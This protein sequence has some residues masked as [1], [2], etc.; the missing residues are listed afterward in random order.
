MKALIKPINGETILTEATQLHAEV[1]E[2]TIQVKSVGLCRTDLYVANGII[3]MT[4]DIILG[5]EFSGIIVDDITGTMSIGQSVAVNPLY[6]DKFMGLHFDG[7][8]CEYINVPITQIHP[9]TLPFQIAAYL[10]PVAASMAVLNVGLNKK[11]VGA[12][13]GRNRI[14]DLTF[15][16]MTHFGYNVTLLNENEEHPPCAFDYIIETVFEEQHVEKM[17]EMLKFGGTLIV[18]SR[19][20]KP[21]P[22]NAS[23][24]VAKSLVFKAANYNDFGKSLTWLER[25]KRYIEPLLGNSYHVDNWKQAFAEASGSESKKTFIHF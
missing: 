9:T 11:Q 20:T 19:K 12:I 3:P 21:V 18:K 2:V 4:T 25:N 17:M 6:G 8:L 16:I 13:Y 23:K 7:A 22:I 14:A 15:L 5:H 24:M 1:G 10:E